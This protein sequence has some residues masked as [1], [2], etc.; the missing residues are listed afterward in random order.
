MIESGPQSPPGREPDSEPPKGL[1]AQ[2][3]RTPRWVK[4]FG[5]AALVLVLI[6]VIV[7]LAGGG[8]HGH[9]MR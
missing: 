8:F 7:H 9:G 6:V 2:D 1:P 4:M 3:E 5:V